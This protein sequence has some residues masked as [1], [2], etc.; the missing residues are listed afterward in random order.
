MQFNAGGTVDTAAVFIDS[1]Y[2]SKIL[3]LAFNSTRIN[4]EKFSDY[5]CSGDYK[6]LRTYYYD[7]MPYQDNPPTEEQRKRYAAHDSF[8]YNL[9]RLNRF[10]VR[11]GKLIYIPAVNDFIQKRVDVWLS[12]DLVRMSWD[13][14]IKKAVLV[15]GDSDF[16]PAI[17]AAKDAGV[18]TVLYYSK[19]HPQINAIDELLYACDERI[20]IT[21][22]L[23]DACKRT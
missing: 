22:D 23:I 2:L 1:G 12:V 13:H 15:T 21:K 10:E 19:G 20:E 7:C 3:K 11:L 17:Q 4:Y 9:R 6:R 14:Q 5:L 16:V 18:L 8:L